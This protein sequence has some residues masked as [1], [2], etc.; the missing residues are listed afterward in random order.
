MIAVVDDHV[1]LLIVIGAAASARLPRRL[2]HDDILA[3][4]REPDSGG[5]AGQSGTDDV[6]RARHQM[7]A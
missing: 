4:L 7:N 6:D 3:A 5:K 1:E 2:V